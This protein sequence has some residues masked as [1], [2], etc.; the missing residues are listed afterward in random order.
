M[1]RW[2]CLDCRTSVELTRHG[3]CQICGSEAVDTMERAGLDKSISS[4]HTPINEVVA[5]HLTVQ[6]KTTMRW[7]SDWEPAV[8]VDAV[9]TH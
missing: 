8:V 7:Q 2:W 3:C 1:E 6:M 9:L 4:I 5:E